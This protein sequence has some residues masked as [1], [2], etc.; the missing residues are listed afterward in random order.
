[1]FNRFF[2]LETHAVYEIMR[3]IRIECCIPKATNTHSEYV[4]IIAFS[5]LQ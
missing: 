1:M 3:L 5:L 2:F 4:I